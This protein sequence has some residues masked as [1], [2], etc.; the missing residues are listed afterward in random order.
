MEDKTL[1]LAVLLIGFIACNNA[2]QENSN[3]EETPTT[4]VKNYT[5]PNGDFAHSVY[6]WLKEPENLEHRTA[7]EASLKKFIF[8]SVDITTYHIGVPADTHREVI[9]NSYTYSLLVT[10]KDKAAQDRYQEDPAHKLFIEESSPLWEKVLVYD[11]E[12]ILN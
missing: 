10:F 2:V 11:S 1:L 8:S 7:F 9:D 12:N 5:I 6:I 3:T 4:E